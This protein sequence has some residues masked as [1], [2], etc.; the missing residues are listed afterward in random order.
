[1]AD[2]QNCLISPIF[3]VFASRFFAQN[4]SSVLLDWFFARFWHV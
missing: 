4:N 3:G 1:M 2:F